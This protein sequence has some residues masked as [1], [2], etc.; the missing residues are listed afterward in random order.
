M[1]KK[2]DPR[3]HSAQ[4]ILNRTIDT[5]FGCG[6][7]FDAHIEPAR[8]RCYYHF[9]RPLTEEEVREV[10]SR[11]N[12]V[13]QANMEIVEEMYPKEEAQRLFNLSRIPDD[14]GATVRIVKVGDYDTCP[15][16]GPH[17]KTTGEIGAFQIYSTS[18]E[19]GVLKVRY[20]LLD[21]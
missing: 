5:M 21:E 8:S 14:P 3:M 12:E 11:V 19:E 9:D 2:Y 10:E 7:S 1:P 17:V 6:R 18:Y 16:I 15:C 13:I 20:K 4:H